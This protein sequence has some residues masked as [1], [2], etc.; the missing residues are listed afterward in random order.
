VPLR[1]FH[2]RIRQSP[3]YYETQLDNWLHRYTSALRKVSGRNVADN[4]EER[5][6]WKRL[7]D[8]LEDEAVAARRGPI[9]K[10]TWSPIHFTYPTFDSIPTSAIRTAIR[11][12]TSMDVRR[13]AWK[14]VEAAARDIRM[15]PARSNN[16][17]EHQKRSLLEAAAIALPIA[18][19]RTP[20]YLGKMVPGQ[21]D[22][23]NR[24]SRSIAGLRQLG[25][26]EWANRGFTLRQ[27]QA[28][29]EAALQY[30]RQTSRRICA[31]MP[32]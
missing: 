8:R 6:Q 1:T 3:E 27:F 20:A 30:A 23:G 32:E 25:P 15:I 10:P 17:T 14:Q 2:R 7:F 24:P 26:D 13:R 19:G 11:A 21:L 29:S 16:L 22:L 9:Y 5:R 31:P 4:E 28:P 12:N 18:E